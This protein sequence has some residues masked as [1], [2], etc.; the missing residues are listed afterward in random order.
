VNARAIQ[1]ALSAA[2]SH[3]QLTSRHSMLNPPSFSNENAA[4]SFAHEPVNHAREVAAR[5]VERLESCD[6]ATGAPRVELHRI[7]TAAGDVEILR[8]IAAA[9]DRLFTGRSRTTD[10]SLLS[11]SARRAFPQ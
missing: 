3:E 5:Y 1:S 8:A 10:E 9:V 2:I 11:F 4:L 6:I 7:R